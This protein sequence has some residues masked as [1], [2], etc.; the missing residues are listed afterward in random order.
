VKFTVS[1][2]RETSVDLMKRLASRLP[3]KSNFLW[4]SLHDP[5]PQLA[6]QTLNMWVNEYVSVAGDLKRKNMVEF[7]NILGGQL[8]FAERSL[9]DAET[10]L[11]NFRV[12]TIT[13]PAEGAPVTAG[14][15]MTRGP[16]L[17][18]FFDKKIEY[19]NLRHDREALEK[20]ISGNAAGT[21]ALQS[22][23]L[24]PSVVNS[25]GG[26]QLKQSFSLL[27]TKQAALAA[28]RQIYTDQYPAVRDLINEV[29]N[30]QTKTIPQQTV[31]LLAQLKERERDYS[32]RVTTQSADVQAIPTRTIEEM[33]LRRAVTV[34]EGLYTTLKSRYAEA[35]LAEASAAPDVN[36]PIRPS[37]HCGQRRTPHRA[38][39]AW[40]WWRGWAPPSGSR[41]SWTVSTSA[42]GT[43][44]RRRTIWGCRSAVR[45]LS[46]RR[47]GSTASRRSR[48]RHSSNRSEPYA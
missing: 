41:C 7:A 44:S 42:S 26:E 11:E 4:L 31:G 1:T 37:P 47:G 28:V 3:D 9:R 35:K 22:V 24:I 48:S 5:D 2:P 6:A 19:D 39:W 15:E 17:Q 10:A 29:N 25:P 23:L 14:L 20:V 43:R 45:C 30:I 32:A 13:L 16:A 38:S 36:V 27:Y 34:S 18:S 21:A 8:Q 33:R 40:R 46:S 12:H